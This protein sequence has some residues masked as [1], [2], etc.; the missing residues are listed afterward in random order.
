MGRK[1]KYAEPRN[2][3]CG[4][5]TTIPNKVIDC[6]NYKKLSTDAKALLLE[7][8]RMFTGQNNGDISLE[9]VKMS[10]R[11]WTQRRLFRARHEL[12][13]YRFLIVTRRGGNRIV[14]LYAL[15][16]INVHKCRGKHHME[17]TEYPGEEYLAE[18]PVW[19]REKT[20]PPK[21]LKA[22]VIPIRDQEDTHDGF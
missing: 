6:A 11:G 9:L 21:F 4:T 10:P 8:G 16:W 12:E 17:P 15:S 5:Y 3:S 20:K 14:R 19:T 22:K 2:Y 7:A 18:Q 13:Y 1:K